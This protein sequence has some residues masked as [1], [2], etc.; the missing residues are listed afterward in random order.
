MAVR[1]QERSGEYGRWGSWKRSSFSFWSAGCAMCDWV[2]WRVGPFQLTNANCRHCSFYFKMMMMMIFFYFQ[3]A[4]EALTPWAFSS[5]QFASN[6]K[7]PQHGQHWV[8]QQLLVQ[9][10]EGQLGWRLSVG[11]WQLPV[12]G[13]YACLL[14]KTSWTTTALYCLLAV[15]E[16]NALLMLRVV[17][18]ALQPILNSSNKISRICFLFNIISIVQNKYKINSMW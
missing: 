5:F 18:S 7:W 6:A 3:S 15:R 13:H 10:W 1:W 11:R 14:C 2:V 8:L 4:H 17:R 9:L 16:P 12:A